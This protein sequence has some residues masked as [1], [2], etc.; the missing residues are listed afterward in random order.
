MIGRNPSTS[1][2]R[3]FEVTGFL[4]EG[5]RVVPVR[6]S[7]TDRAVGHRGE[8]LNAPVCNLLGGRVRERVPMY[9]NSWFTGARNAAGFC[10]KGEETVAMGEKPWNGI[11]RQGA[12]DAYLENGA[13]GR[14]RGPHRARSRGP[15]VQL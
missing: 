2:R 8:V 9:A 5:R 3:L 13:G 4:M 10:P 1:K 7:G 12:N 15:H 6:V 11:G 14:P